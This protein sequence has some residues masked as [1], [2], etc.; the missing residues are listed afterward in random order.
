MVLFS[1]ALNPIILKMAL[2]LF[3]FDGHIRAYCDDLPVVCRHILTGLAALAQLFEKMF[4]FSNFYTKPNA[5]LY[6]SVV[7]TWMRSLL[8]CAAFL[9]QSLVSLSVSGWPANI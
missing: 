2:A 4:K 8:L 7:M 1:I 9:E 3:P 6:P 5:R